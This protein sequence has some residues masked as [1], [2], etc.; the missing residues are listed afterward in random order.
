MTAMRGS[1]GA[2]EPSVMGI[3][4][5]VIEAH[6]AVDAA[7]AVA[8]AHRLAERIEALLT[9]AHCAPQTAFSLRLALG[10]ARNLKDELA[11]AA[12]R[13]G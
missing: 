9:G 6:V 7:A 1:V 3:E 13:L 8:E 10:L 2:S 5:P 12:R 4:G 11:V